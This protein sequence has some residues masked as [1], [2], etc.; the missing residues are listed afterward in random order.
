M[1]ERAALM[2]LQVAPEKHNSLLLCGSRPASQRRRR[3]LISGAMHGLI[4][5]KAPCSRRMTSR[6]QQMRNARQ[7]LGRSRFE[8]LAHGA[9]HGPVLLA[10]QLGGE[11]A[12]DSP[13]K[14]S[15]RSLFARDARHHRCRAFATAARPQK[16]QCCVHIPPSTANHARRVDTS[17]RSVLVESSGAPQICRA[18]CGDLLAI[19]AHSKTL[20]F[21]D[22][23]A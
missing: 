4:A 5:Q 16:L 15:L 12:P 18:V 2:C 6:C 1:Q 7:E 9:A 11:I 10:L 3:S 17:D 13:V 22:D 8:A 14:R 23:E 19:P 21:D 20:L